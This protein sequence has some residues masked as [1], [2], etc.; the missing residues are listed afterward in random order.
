MSTALVPYVPLGRGRLRVLS[1]A[2]N[3]VANEGLGG[4]QRDGE[5][6]RRSVV[7]FDG[8]SPGHE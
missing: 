6:L 8:L 7:F 3:W 4:L 1:F 2:A 5:D